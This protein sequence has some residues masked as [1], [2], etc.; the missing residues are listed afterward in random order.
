M[1]DGDSFGGPSGA[2]V[3]WQVLVLPLSPIPG[4]EKSQLVSGEATVAEIDGLEPDTEYTVRVR[5]HVAGVDGAPA[6]VVV[7]TGEW[8]LASCSH[9]SLADPPCCAF[10]TALTA[11]SIAAQ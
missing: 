1:E 3:A 11:H 9:A 10:L 8:T 7:R 2:L 5:T 4:P 6:S